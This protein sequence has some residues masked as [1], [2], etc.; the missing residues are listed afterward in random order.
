MYTTEL[1]KNVKPIE[2]AED[3]ERFNEVCDRL[4]IP[5]PPGGTATTVEEAQRIAAS[6]GKC[7]TSPYSVPI[8]HAGP[9]RGCSTK[10]RKPW[11]SRPL[12]VKS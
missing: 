7:N 5:Q 2:T 12:R 1:S 10:P 8:S 11:S 3:R 6:V 9:S 4:G